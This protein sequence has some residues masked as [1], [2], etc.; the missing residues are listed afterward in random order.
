MRTIFFGRTDE[1]DCYSFLVDTNKK[2]NTHAIYFFLL[3]DYGVNDKNHPSS[4]LHFQTLIKHLA[5][6]SIAGIHPSFASNFNVQQLKVEIV[7][8]S[9]IIHRDI[10]H[11][12]QH[13]GMLTFPVTYKALMN[14][15]VKHDYSLGYTNM[16]GFRA[17]MCFPFKWY[18]IADEMETSLILHPFCVNDVALDKESK[19]DQTE[20]KRIL[21]TVFNE[22]K[23]HGGEF[24]VVFHNDMLSNSKT[25][26][27]W[28]NV[29]EANQQMT[30][31]NS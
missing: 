17:S 26:L 18:N 3:G 8:L 23:A 31:I 12:R 9:S 24:I 2:H 30:A 21:S 29:Y 15:G 4:N 1:F 27:N 7:R 6:Y 28:R 11:S 10:V 16:N 19:S 14:A 5:D 20:A 13:F 22:V 25:G